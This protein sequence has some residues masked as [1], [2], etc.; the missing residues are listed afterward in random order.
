MGGPR[1]RTDN[2]QPSRTTNLFTLDSHSRRNRRNR[3]ASEW[4]QN[5]NTIEIKAPEV[6]QAD[7]EQPLAAPS[8]TPSRWLLAGL[9]AAVAVF[10]TVIYS[11]IHE[12]AHAETTLGIR[13]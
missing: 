9:A 11:G 8:R 1:L 5:M 4:R 10:G 6:P 13:T 3:D 2:Q 7:S 12:R